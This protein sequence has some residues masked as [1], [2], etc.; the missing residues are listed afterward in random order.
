MMQNLLNVVSNA[1][2]VVSYVKTHPKESI[3]AASIV[4][5]GL[6]TSCGGEKEPFVSQQLGSSISQLVEDVRATPKI[7]GVSYHGG[8]EDGGPIFVNNVPAYPNGFH[9]VMVGYDGDVTIQTS[10]DRF[11]VNDTKKIEITGRLDLKRTSDG[12]YGK[13]NCPHTDNDEQLT[14]CP[15]TED[16]EQLIQ[17]VALFFEANNLDTSSTSK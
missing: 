6:M 12:D 8:L 10:K 5:L 15:L 9:S 2:G 4:G 17:N 16:D 3:V 14:Y 7:R 13:I 1:Y 11:I